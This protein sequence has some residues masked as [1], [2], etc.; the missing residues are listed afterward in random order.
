VTGAGFD[1]GDTA[2]TRFTAW[3]VIVC[4]AVVGLAA[5]GTDRVAE[6]I[7]G[8]H[9]RRGAVLPGRDRLAQRSGQP[10]GQLRNNGR[11]ERQ[12]VREHGGVRLGVGKIEGAAEHVADLVVQPGPRGGEG[13]RREVAAVEGLL[14]RPEIVGILD[15]AGQSQRQGT[16][17]F[18]GER[19]VDRVGLRCPQGV[20]AVGQ[21][22]Q[23]GRDRQAHR[24]G[25]GEGGVVDH[26]G[27]EHAVVDPGGLGSLLGH[28]PHVGGL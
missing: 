28:A 25:P 20:D 15:D 4:Q 10:V 5:R 7:K 2:R 21:A 22:V 9:R 23:P 12:H 14:P 11:V 16:G 27:R 18:Q 3:D 24:E 1:G 13:H 17:P 6:P 8:G 26:G 19:L